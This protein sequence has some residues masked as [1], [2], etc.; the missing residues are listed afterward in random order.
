MGLFALV[1]FHGK[2]VTS[3]ILNKKIKVSNLMPIMKEEGSFQG[4]GQI[5]YRYYSI[6]MYQLGYCRENLHLSGVS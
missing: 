4:D 1:L 2:L 3:K 5:K 6:R